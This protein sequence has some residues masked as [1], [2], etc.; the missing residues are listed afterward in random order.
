MLLFVILIADPIDI[1]KLKSK[2]NVTI[3]DEGKF[4]ENTMKRNSWKIENHKLPY[5][6]QMVLHRQTGLISYTKNCLIK[7]KTQ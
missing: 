6:Q 2:W 4:L 3:Y 1:L 7:L 5:C